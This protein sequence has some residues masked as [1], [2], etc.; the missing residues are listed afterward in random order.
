MP[1]YVL[2]ASESGRGVFGVSQSLNIVYHSP[3]FLYV[4]KSTR[5]YFP[6]NRRVRGDKLRIVNTSMALGGRTL[7]CRCEVRFL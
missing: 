2:L 5:I 7:S 6:L 1:I 3:A 4:L